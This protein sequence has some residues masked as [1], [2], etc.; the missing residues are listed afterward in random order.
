M[1]AL[2]RRDLLAAAAAAGAAAT[3]LPAHAA[4]FDWKRFN[5]SSLHFMVSFV[6]AL[7]RSSSAPIFIRTPQI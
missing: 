2:Y 5:G 6:W 3:A 7:V 4:D 1:T